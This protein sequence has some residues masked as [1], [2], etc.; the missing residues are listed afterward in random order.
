MIRYQ[1]RYHRSIMVDGRIKYP[2]GTILDSIEDV[3]AGQRDRLLVID[4]GAKAAKV[5]ELEP[6]PGE[7]EDEEE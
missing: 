5:E 3:P 6:L 1:V 7:D 4:D 2:Q